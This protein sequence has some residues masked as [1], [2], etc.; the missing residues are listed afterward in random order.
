M[1]VRWCEIVGETCTTKPKSP[2]DA[3]AWRRESERRRKADQRIADAK[4][5][6]ARKVQRIRRDSA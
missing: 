2:M 6:C 1:A 4:A 5:D 3:D